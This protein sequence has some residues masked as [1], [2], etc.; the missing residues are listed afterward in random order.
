MVYTR[1]KNINGNDYLYLQENN[2]VNGK[3]VTSHIGYIGRVGVPLGTTQTNT[4]TQKYNKELE[5]NAIKKFGVTNNINEAGYIM[6]NGDMLDFSG[7]NEG[8]SPNNRS[9]D[10]RDINK[11]FDNKNLNLTK[12]END[13][14]KETNYGYVSSFTSRTGAIRYDGSG[15]NRI[16]LSTVPTQEQKNIIIKNFNKSKRENPSEILIVD[17]EINNKFGN[18]QTVSKEYENAEDFNKDFPVLE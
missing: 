14:I 15:G 1:I 6:R 13:Y 2:R 12:K 8:G 9:L 7:K 5:E 4:S 16:D 17:I 11:I 18:K 3:I 10:H